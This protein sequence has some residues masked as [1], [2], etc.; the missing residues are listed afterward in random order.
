MPRA[1]KPRPPT[2]SERLEALP[3]EPW[4]FPGRSPKH[5]LSTC[6][7]TANWPEHAPVIEAEVEAF[8][9]CF[10]DLFYEM[11]RASPISAAFTPNTIESWI[12]RIV[13][14]FP[15]ASSRSW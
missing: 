3:G 1:P 13:T 5:D 9:R 8:E 14:K 10:G 11:A 15:D 12:G 6:T 4:P 2:A 7:V